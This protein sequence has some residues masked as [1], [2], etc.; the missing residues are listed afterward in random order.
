MKLM[1]ELSG[2]EI[3]EAIAEWML[4]HYEIDVRIPHIAL[5]YEPDEDEEDIGVF[6]A[7]IELGDSH[8][9]VK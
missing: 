9:R 2:L 5:G 1:Y 3:R 8:V 6:S 4:R 7:D